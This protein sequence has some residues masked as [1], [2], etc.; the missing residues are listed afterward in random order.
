[1]GAG[2]ESRLWL[3]CALLTTKRRHPKFLQLNLNWDTL[4]SMTKE[5]I[6][7]K[8]MCAQV[9]G[10]HLKDIH[11]LKDLNRN[12]SMHIIFLFYFHFFYFALCII[13]AP[14]KHGAWNIWAPLLTLTS[15]YKS[16]NLYRMGTFSSWHPTKTCWKCTMTKHNISFPINMEILPFS[17][18]AML[19]NKWQQTNSQTN[20][21]IRHSAVAFI[22]YK[23]WSTQSKLW[24][25]FCLECTMQRIGVG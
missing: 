25:K 6:G 17:A 15:I 21:Q 5:I 16:M 9:C 1:M 3:H 2:V 24:K 20:K 23:Y 12:R 19:L 18:N 13:V 14:F 11:I 10:G 7:L 8:Q 4:P 22:D